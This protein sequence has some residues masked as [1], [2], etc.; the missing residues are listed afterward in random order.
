M[1]PSEPE[2]HEGEHRPV[3]EVGRE[4]HA[5]GDGGVGQGSDGDVGQGPVARDDEREEEEPVRDPGERRQHWGREEEEEEDEEH[6]PE[7]PVGELGR[8]TGQDGR[9]H[10]TPVQA[11]NHGL[12][13]LPVQDALE[14]VPR[15]RGELDR[16]LGRGPED[17]AQGAEDER[18]CVRDVF[19]SGT[20]ARQPAVPGP[21]KAP[22]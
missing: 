17:A 4:G 10:G 8:E 3:D 16:E 5:H 18:E 20:P 13:A 7:Q 2:D 21:D 12:V 1:P 11:G 9:L 19:P 15:P 22:A 6:P 14:T